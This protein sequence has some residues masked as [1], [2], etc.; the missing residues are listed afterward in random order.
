MVTSPERL[1]A[2]RL[3]FA[4]V[5]LYVSPYPKLVT[6]HVY[7]RFAAS[8]SGCRVSDFVNRCD[9]FFLRNNKLE[10]CC[11]RSTLDAICF[12]R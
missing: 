4:S 2:L 10:V 7:S 6:S 1:F 11:I 12:C 5:T 8:F 9:F 3:V